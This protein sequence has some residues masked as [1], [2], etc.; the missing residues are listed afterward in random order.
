MD[1]KQ[2][3]E[4]LQKLKRQMKE[5]DKILDDP[6]F[7][8]IQEPLKESFGRFIVL[9]IAV[10]ARDYLGISPSEQATI[11]LDKKEAPR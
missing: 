7:K 4:E 11:K 2:F 8:D 6:E 3:K 1:I 10:L 5:I 9:K